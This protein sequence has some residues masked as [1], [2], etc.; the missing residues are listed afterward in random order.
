MT[1]TNT[2]LITGASS[3]IGLEL[4]RLHAQQGGDVVLVAR[5]ENK[6][7]ALKEEL[8]QS[9]GVNVPTA[10]YVTQLPDNQSDFDA[11]FGTR[12]TL[13]NQVAIRFSSE[14]ANRPFLTENAAMW[15]FFENDL[16]RRL[17][18]LDADASMSQKVK[19]LLMELL[20][21]GQVSAE[22]VA[23]KLAI[24]KRT[25]QR[26]LDSESANFQSLLSALRSELAR[27]YLHRSSMSLQEIAFLLGFSDANTFIR[28]FSKWHGV[29]PGQFRN[30]H[31][32]GA[33]RDYSI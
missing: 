7:I 25:L 27:Q 15:S 3:G 33:R 1:Y 18:E 22:Q 20:P 4:A 13:S 31:D 17:A 12:L 19:A 21:S 28:A 10:L 9:Y 23:A 29:S 26:K 16:A 6:L 2:A 32:S 14:D 8:E 24:S 5:S 30:Q 11:Y